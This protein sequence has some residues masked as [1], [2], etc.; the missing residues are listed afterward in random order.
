VCM[1]AC[2]YVYVHVHVACIDKGLSELV[3]GGGY[4]R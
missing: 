2:V 1:R 3:H 4:D